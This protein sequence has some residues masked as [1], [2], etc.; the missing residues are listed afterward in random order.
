MRALALAAALAFAPF[1]W[2]GEPQ[3]ITVKPVETDEVLANPGIGW[4]TFHRTRTQD[5]NLPDWIPSTVH[6]ARWGWGTFEPQPG[7]IDTAFLDKVLK[8]SREAGQQLAFRVMCCSTSPGHPYQP[9]W[10]NDAG[11]KI[12][13]VQYAHRR[14]SPTGSS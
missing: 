13:D 10:L 4:E 1:L 5:K 14:A 3:M 12:V 2:A 8:E 7:K 9:A 11:G 6:Y